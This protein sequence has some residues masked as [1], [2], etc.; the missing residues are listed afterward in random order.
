MTTVIDDLARFLFDRQA[1]T[2]THDTAYMDE[3]WSK[4]EVRE[5]WIDEATAIVEFLAPSV[6][7][8]SR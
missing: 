7:E 2:Y 6:V 4:W 8:V 3:M 5:F 1:R